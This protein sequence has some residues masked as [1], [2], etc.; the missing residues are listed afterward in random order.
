MVGTT[1][2]S[3]ESHPPLTHTYTVSETTLGERVRTLRLERGLSQDDLAQAIGKRGNSVGR[4]E[5]DAM[6]ASAETV[7]ELARVFGVSADYLL[8][9]REGDMAQEA[10]PGLADFLASPEGHDLSP[11]ERDG[12]AMIGRGLQRM[13]LQPTPYSY[14]AAVGIAR[15]LTP[16]ATR[17]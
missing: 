12:L 2:T 4:I 14:A 3:F 1:L 13:G 9:G 11:A 6:G 16:A 17:R 10:P 15:M 5:R 7:V 8:T